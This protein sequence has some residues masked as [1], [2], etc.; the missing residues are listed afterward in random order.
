MNAT[1]ASQPIGAESWVRIVAVGL[2]VYGLV[3]LEKLIRHRGGP[4]DPDAGA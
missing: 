1:F 2:A 4:P 3:G